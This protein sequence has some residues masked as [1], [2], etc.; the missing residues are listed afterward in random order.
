MSTILHFYIGQTFRSFVIPE[1]HIQSYSKDTGY[2]I[3]VTKSSTLESRVKNDSLPNNI[4][5]SNISD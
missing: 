4:P 3:V 1:K 5:I 2:T